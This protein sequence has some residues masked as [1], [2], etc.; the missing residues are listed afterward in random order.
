MNWIYITLGVLAVL[1]FLAQIRVGVVVEY[2]TRLV[3]RA[4]VGGISFRVYPSDRVGKTKTKPPSDPSKKKQPLTKYAPAIP[5]VIK[6]AGRVIKQLRVDNLDLDIQV[7]GGDPSDV[8]LNYG[9]LNSAVG[10]VW[11]TFRNVLNV[12]DADIH[13][14]FD[15]DAGCSRVQGNVSVSWKIWQ[16]VSTVIV[17]ARDV[18]V[19]AYKNRMTNKQEGLVT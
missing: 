16:L 17:F 10:S 18:L 8:A 14:G 11:G 19:V 13:L 4:R 1:F 7:G 15:F 2:M 12:K 9:R 6:A 5:C 3:V